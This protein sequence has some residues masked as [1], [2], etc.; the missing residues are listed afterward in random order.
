M[1]K[2]L[3]AGGNAPAIAETQ[4]FRRPAG[5]VLVEQ[6]HADALALTVS[7]SLLKPHGK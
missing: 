3:D 7:E 1:A 6:S 5:C 2:V 4:R